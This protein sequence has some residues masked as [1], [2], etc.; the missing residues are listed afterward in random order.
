MTHNTHYT[1]YE[2]L[3]STNSDVSIRRRHL[4]FLVTEVF[5]SVNNLN[6]HP[7][8]EFFKK[9]F[10]PYD[11]RKVDTL[12][13][14]PAHSTRYVTN[15]LLFGIS[16]LWNLPSEIKE[17]FFTEEFEKRLKEHGALYVKFVSCL[18]IC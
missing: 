18:D 15:S 11:F 16:L 5:K 14:L 1:T 4:G 10:F 3:I 13:L 7:M 9:N 6:P 8:W 2:E 17:S 12:H